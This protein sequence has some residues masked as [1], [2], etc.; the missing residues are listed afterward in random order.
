[1]SDFHQGKTGMDLGEPYDKK[2]RLHYGFYPEEVQTQNGLM[3]RLD[4]QLDSRIKNI[5]DFKE[6]SIM[7]VKSVGKNGNQIIGYYMIDSVLS[8]DPESL[9]ENIIKFR[10]LGTNQPHRDEHN[11]VVR[12]DSQS[13]L[14]LY[15]GP[16]LQR[17]GPRFFEFLDNITEEGSVDFIPYDDKKEAIEKA[18]GK[19]GVHIA[20]DE[21]TKEKLS[22]MYQTETVNSLDE[23]DNALNQ[24]FKNPRESNDIAEKKLQVGLSFAITNKETTDVMQITDINEDTK[25]ITLW[26]GA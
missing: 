12:S 16:A 8:D 7:R 22:Q 19:D 24:C 26:N 3:Q 10:F 4:T 9:D 1:M 18:L 14:S 15:G 20:S 23:L 13:T 25:E 5:S 21:D 2:F 17:S 6:G 11:R